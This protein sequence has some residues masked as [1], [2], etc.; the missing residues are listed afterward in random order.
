MG[1]HRYIQQEQENKEEVFEEKV[2]EQGL[3][4]EINI[5]KQKEEPVVQENLITKI[6]NTIL[7]RKSQ[8]FK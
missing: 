5:T 1:R 8:P 7:R 6:V 4:E 2:Q 3:T